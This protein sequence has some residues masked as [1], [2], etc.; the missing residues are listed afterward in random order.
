MFTAGTQTYFTFFYLIFFIFPFAADKPVARRQLNNSVCYWNSKKGRALIFRCQNRYRAEFRDFA[1]NII[2]GFFWRYTRS[3]LKLVGLFQ[4]LAGKTS[5][6][7]KELAVLHSK[8]KGSRQ[9][10]GGAGGL[11]VQ[12]LPRKPG[13]NSEKSVS[14]PNYY[15]RLGQGT[16]FSE[17]LPGY[18]CST[19]VWPLLLLQGFFLFFQKLSRLL[20]LY[21]LVVS[22]SAARYTFSKP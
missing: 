8:M 1:W 22:A 12:C 18:Y 17:V 7:L 3:L 6:H 14:Y 4:D 2:L 5:E 15:I 20:L 16:D 9:G 11:W 10:V 19:A 21:F 13:R